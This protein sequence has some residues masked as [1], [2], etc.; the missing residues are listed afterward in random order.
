MSARSAGKELFAIDC[1]N[2]F[3]MH[4]DEDTIQQGTAQWCGCTCTIRS[5]DVL[6]INE[7]IIWSTTW[8][9]IFLSFYILE[10]FSLSCC[11]VLRMLLRAWTAFNK[12]RSS[13]SFS[14]DDD[15][16]VISLPK[17][18]VLN[19]RNLTAA[20]LWTLNS[21][22]NPAGLGNER[23]W[24]DVNNPPQLYSRCCMHVAW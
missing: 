20:Q 12:N 5:K 23:T 22:L 6:G 9:C 16:D 14:S 24:L 1:I 13:P 19:L 4:P 17:K 15:D 3:D 18:E 10:S 7:K 8:P 11:L 2:L 21:R